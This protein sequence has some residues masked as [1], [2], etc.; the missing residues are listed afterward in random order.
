MPTAPTMVLI[1]EMRPLL[2]R[3]MDMMLFEDQVGTGWLTAITQRNEK[4]LVYLLWA[5]LRYKD[6]S[7]TPS[8]VSEYLDR[9]R[10]KD[11]S[12]AEL[13]E[14][15]GQALRNSGFLPREV[16]NGIPTMTDANTPPAPPGGGP[17]P[18]PG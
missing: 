17:V 4:H 14:G 2:Y 8:K 3:S 7:I 9:A 12:L 10:D 1:D 15:V 11:R 13:W 6:Q 18:G 5:G 16:Q